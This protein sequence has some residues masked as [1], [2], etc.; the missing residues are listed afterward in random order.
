MQ[1]DTAATLCRD[2]VDW[3]QLTVDEP[4]NLRISIE[5]FHFTGDLNLFAYDSDLIML[6]GV[7]SQSPLVIEGMSTSNDECI[8]LEG[9]EADTYFFEVR[10]AD[11]HMQAPYAMRVEEVA[12]DEGCF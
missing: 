2:T 8:L 10:G 12:L 7:V 9:A 4:K 11:A 5:F 1:S 3:F 6:N